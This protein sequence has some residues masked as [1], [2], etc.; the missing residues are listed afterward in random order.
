MIWWLL[1]Y[2]WIAYRKYVLIRPVES[3]LFKYILTLLAEE[4]NLTVEL[5][6]IGYY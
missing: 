5:N 1:N 2:L 4:P 3:S 6:Y